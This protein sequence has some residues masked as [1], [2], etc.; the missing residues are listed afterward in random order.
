MIF[1]HIELSPIRVIYMLPMYAVF[2]LTGHVVALKSI[3]SS[4]VTRYIKDIANFLQYF[5]NNQSRNVC[6]VS[7]SITH[8]KK[9]VLKTRCNDLMM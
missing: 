8:Q 1:P 3:K 9:R 4:T 6:K 2:L 7:N 5:D